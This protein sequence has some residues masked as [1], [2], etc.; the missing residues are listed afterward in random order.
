[1]VTFCDLLATEPRPP[2]VA[3]VCDDIAC[4]L[5]GS[6]EICSKL[7]AA[8]GAAGTASNDG[9]STWLRSPCLGLCEQAPA[10]LVLRSGE[11]RESASLTTITSE[12]QILSA[13]EADT[14]AFYTPGSQR[15]EA[16]RK[17]APQAG[18]P[19]LV[20]LQRVDRVDPASLS[21]Y[22]E[23]GGYRAGP[24]DRDRPA[25]IEELTSTPG[26]RRRR[27]SR[28]AQNRRR[29]CR[30]GAHALGDLQRHWCDRGRRTECC[31]KRT[32]SPSSKR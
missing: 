21:D 26:T 16:A 32:R 2:A 7:E 1:M 28:R 14:T 31:S 30:E 13:L 9:Q 29:R 12:H 6:R 11:V 23:N 19:G 25:V 15:L 18:A 10:A 5:K 24:G 22:R 4:R 3:H 20:L 8:A 27:L 17:S